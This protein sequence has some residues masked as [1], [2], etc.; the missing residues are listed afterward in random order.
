[1]IISGVHGLDFLDPD[2][3]CIQHVQSKVFV[4]VAGGGMDF[5]F[6]EKTLL[7]VCL[8]D[9]NPESN[10]SRI[11]CV[12][13]APDPEQIGNFRNRIGTSDKQNS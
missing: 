3:C 5:V 11:A 7:V 9:T 10:S 4:A 13:L 6:A 12:M 2:S 8:A 1:M